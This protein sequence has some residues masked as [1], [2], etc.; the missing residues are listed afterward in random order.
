MANDENNSS[1]PEVH[2]KSVGPRLFLKMS[3]LALS[4]LPKR[5]MTHLMSDEKN[6]KFSTRAVWQ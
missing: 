6:V 4:H 3:D 1:N 2:H 5:M